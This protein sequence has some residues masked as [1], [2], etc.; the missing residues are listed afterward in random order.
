MSGL[1][2]MP[3]CELRLELKNVSTC[4]N[5]PGTTLGLPAHISAARLPS[6]SPAMQAGAFASPKPQLTRASH[7]DWAAQGNTCAAN[8]SPKYASA[9]NS[10][11]A[12]V[13]NHTSVHVRVRSGFNKGPPGSKNM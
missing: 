6:P 2:L 11:A 7:V 5:S 4:V 12:R 9:H 3:I 13:R 10:G 1:H 8:R